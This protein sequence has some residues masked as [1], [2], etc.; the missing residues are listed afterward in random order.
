[1][2]EGLAVAERVRNYAINSAPVVVR[3]VVIVGANISDGPQNKEA[4]RGDVQRLRRAHRQA[5]VDLPLG[6]AAPASSATR[7]GRTAAAEY[8]GNTN[9]WAMMSVDEELGYVY[10]PFGTPTNDYYGGHRPGNNLFAES[11][12]CLDATTGKRV[13]HFQACTTA[14]GTTTSRPR[15]SWSTSP[16]TDARSRPSRR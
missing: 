8:T 3:N 4:P 12:V 7:R 11:L 5:A 1:M 15:R 2:I 16:W 9:V 10:L 6:A 13:W 14:C